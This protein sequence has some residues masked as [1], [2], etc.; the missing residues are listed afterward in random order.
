MIGMNVD[1][2]PA[3]TRLAELIRAAR[4][5]QLGDPTPC[6]AYTLGDLIDHVGR[7][8]LSFTAAAEKEF[9]GYTEQLPSGSA[10]GLGDD[11]RERI[12]RDLAT[13][14]NAWQPTEAWTGM[15]R[16]AMMDAPADMVGITA[17]DELVVHG[18]DVA[19]AMGEP[20]SCEPDM[21]AAA[22]KFLDLAANPEAPAGPDV[23]FG[24]PTMLADDAPQI[25]RLVAMAGRDHAWTRPA[26]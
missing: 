19:R 22:Q 2:A 21:L 9:G 3:A 16:I 5:D 10:A 18:W 25:E 8:S 6:P 13:L 24:P 1:F 20:F 17:A 23:A 7:L 11:W 26:S 14:A 12:P 4:D 15:T